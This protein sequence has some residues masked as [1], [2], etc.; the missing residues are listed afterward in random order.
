M[1]AE[2]MYVYYTHRDWHSPVVASEEIAAVQPEEAAG[3]VPIESY[4]VRPLPTPP[5]KPAARPITIPQAPESPSESSPLDGSFSVNGGDTIACSDATFL[6]EV[7]PT[8][9]EVDGSVY[10][11]YTKLRALRDLVEVWI[12]EGGEGTERQVNPFLRPIF[13]FMIEWFKTAMD[14]PRMQQEIYRILDL[15]NNTAVEA[16]LHENGPMPMNDAGGKWSSRVESLGCVF[17]PVVIANFLCPAFNSL[18]SDK[19]LSDLG[20]RM[21]PSALN[22]H[23]R[24]LRWPGDLGAITGSLSYLNSSMG[25]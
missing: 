23:S 15:E 18:C 5:R 16:F 25:V 20:A 21:I 12:P 17:P 7:R 19:I 9:V 6:P 24:H 14:Y 3:A 10:R 22:P 1:S 11:N 4:P 8:P 13:G 2:R